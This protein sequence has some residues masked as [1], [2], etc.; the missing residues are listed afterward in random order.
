MTDAETVKHLVEHGFT[1]SAVPWFEVNIELAPDRWFT[2]VK[3][4]Y[5]P[6]W[7]W[8]QDDP[9]KRRLEAAVFGPPRRD[10]CPLEVLA[11]VHRRNDAMI[12]N[13]PE[14]FCH[15]KSISDVLKHC[16]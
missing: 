6:P 15:P 9:I 3:A 8:H 14:P 1:M 12:R 4:T 7:E 5:R 10:Q 11:E 16:S 13:L 2:F